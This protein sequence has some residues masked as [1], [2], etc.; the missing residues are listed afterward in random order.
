MKSSGERAWDLE[1][2]S[3]WPWT[4]H[5]RRDEQNLI[6]RIIQGKEVGRYF[7]LLGPKVRALS[8]FYALLSIAHYCICSLGYGEDDDDT[9]R[10]ANCELR[11]RRHVR[12]AL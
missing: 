5:L 10:Y 7:V 12:H 11:G 9:R 3:S 4:Q 1:D 6:D 8:P 2:I